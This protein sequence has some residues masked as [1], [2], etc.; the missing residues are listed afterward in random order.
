MLSRVVRLA[1]TVSDYTVGTAIVLTHLAL[2]G[3]ARRLKAA[4][5]PRY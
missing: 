3:R 2:A 4:E 1:G 5:Q